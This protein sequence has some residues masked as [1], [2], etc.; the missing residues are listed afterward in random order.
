MRLAEYAVEADRLDILK[1]IGE[2]MEEQLS[3]LV[4]GAGC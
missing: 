1:A 3:Q 2:D 4:R